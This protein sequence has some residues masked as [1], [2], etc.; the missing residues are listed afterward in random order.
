MQHGKTAKSL[1]GFQRT[2]QSRRL[3]DPGNR[4]QFALRQQVL[5]TRLSD[6]ALSNRRV[7]VS[8]AAHWHFRIVGVNAQQAIESD[9]SRNLL[10]QSRG[11][12]LDGEVPTAGA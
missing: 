8:P 4:G 6:I 11:F 10:Y 12:S 3:Q 1:S 7:S 2:L 9:G 5:E